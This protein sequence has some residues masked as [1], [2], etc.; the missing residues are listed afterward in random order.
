MNGLLINTV[1][2]AMVAGEGNEWVCVLFLFVV[3]IIDR[4]KRFVQDAPRTIVQIYYL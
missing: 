2:S 1:V 3:G 4:A